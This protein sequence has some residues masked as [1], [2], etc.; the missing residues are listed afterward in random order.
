MADPDTASSPRDNID[1]NDDRESRDA[2]LQIN[3][4]GDA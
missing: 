1:N 3:D 4:A 2:D